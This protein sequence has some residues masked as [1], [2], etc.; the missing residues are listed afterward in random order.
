[1]QRGIAF[2]SALGLAL[3]FVAL[4]QPAAVRSG[5][6]PAPRR[7]PFAPGFHDYFRKPR[8]CE[9]IFR[10]R[11]RSTVW[12]ICRDGDFYELRYPAKDGGDRVQNL[13]LEDLQ[14]RLGALPDRAQVW[15]LTEVGDWGESERVRTV[16]A[17]LR[18]SGWQV[19]VIE[20]P[21]GSG[22]RIIDI[23]YADK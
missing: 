19:I 12:I 9:P 8:A 13:G 2:V 11:E 3:M 20:A 21:S 18:R 4:L 22:L 7:L 14:A 23:H 1:M 16:T 5:A 15:V 6:R 17:L 10:E